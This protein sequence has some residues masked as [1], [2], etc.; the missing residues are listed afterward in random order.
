MASNPIYESLL[1]RYLKNQGEEIT[2]GSNK[3]KTILEFVVCMGTLIDGKK[4]KDV[5]WPSNC[6]L[7]SVRRGENEIIPKG[8]T[9]IL[10][11]DYL[12]ILTNEDIASKINDS[13]LTLAGSCELK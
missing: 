10:A 5:K 11:G 2:I 6:L 12:A 13:M 8:D 1:E 7:V 3:N 9:T 4:I